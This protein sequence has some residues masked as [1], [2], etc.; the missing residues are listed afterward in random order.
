[1]DGW[2]DLSSSM[3]TVTIPWIFDVQDG[4]DSRSG[5]LLLMALKLALPIQVQVVRVRDGWPR[6]SR[7][8]EVFPGVQD[9]L[10]NTVAKRMFCTLTGDFSPLS[11]RRIAPAFAT[12]RVITKFPELNA[13][14]LFSLDR[15][16]HPVSR[17]QRGYRAPC[18]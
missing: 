2:C 17:S 4:G 7:F 18:R 16:A 12:S 15:P 8:A 3:Y 6:V 1:M 10:Y 5:R 11:R 9:K 14:L 13:R